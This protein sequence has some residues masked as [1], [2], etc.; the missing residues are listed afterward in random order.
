M[1][2]SFLKRMFTET[3]PEAPTGLIDFA[4]GCLRRP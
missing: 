4:A 2:L 3:D 1:K